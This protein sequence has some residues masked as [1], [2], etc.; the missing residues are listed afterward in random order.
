MIELRPCTQAVALEFVRQHHR[1][2]DAPV[3]DLWRHAV[4]NDDGNLVGVAICGR[5]VARELDDGLT[6]EITRL[7]TVETP[8]ADSMLYAAAKKAADAKGYRR[9]L[10]YFLASEWD[11][12]DP[13]TKRR[14]GGAGARGAGYVFLWRVKGRS[15]DCK[16][17]R[18]IDK[19]PTEDKVALGWGAWS[20]NL[21]KPEDENLPGDTPVETDH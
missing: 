17:R 13:E 3:G 12:F 18:R 15:W 19:H 1:H 5:P 11:R 20:E 10:T 7:C 6:V 21:L 8:N 9:G 16:S 2:H 14:I 4:H